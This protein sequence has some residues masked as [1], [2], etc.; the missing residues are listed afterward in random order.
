MSVIEDNVRQDYEQ[1][2]CNLCSCLLTEDSDQMMF[3]FSEVHLVPEIYVKVSHPGTAQSHE[4]KI[5]LLP[6]MSHRQE[7]Q[8]V[9]T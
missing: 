8:D 2:L 1:T 7:N 4:S 6:L 3:D 9:S 5:L